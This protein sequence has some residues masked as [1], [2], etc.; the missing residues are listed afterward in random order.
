MLV[1]A[2]K[3]NPM[4][5]PCIMKSFAIQKAS[6]PWLAPELRRN[7]LTGKV[8]GRAGFPDGSQIQTSVIKEVK[9][10]LVTTS[11]GTVYKLVGPAHKKFREFLKE[12]GLSYNGKAPL[13]GAE[14][15]WVNGGW[16]NKEESDRVSSPPKGN[17]NA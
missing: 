12:K 16:K 8:Y 7:V 5:E 2:V 10:R 1:A 9:G 4:N 6:D 15:Y 11:S 3:G 13:D 14:E 17:N